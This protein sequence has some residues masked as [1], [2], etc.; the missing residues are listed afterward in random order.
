MNKKKLFDRGEDH[1]HFGLRK[2]TIGV[3]S[4]LLGTTFMIYGGHAV[5][6]A[7]TTKSPANQPSTTEVESKPQEAN[8]PVIVSGQKSNVVKVKTLL[9]KL[10]QLLRLQ[11]QQLKQRQLNQH[12]QIS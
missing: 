3:A 1:Q 8:K 11:F 12:K 9:L 5:Q 2:L 6:A 4:V 7:D 10:S